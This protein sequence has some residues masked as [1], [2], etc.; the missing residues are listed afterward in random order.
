MKAKLEGMDAKANYEYNKALMQLRTHYR[1]LV[2][3]MEHYQ[4]ERRMTQKVGE[5]IIQIHNAAFND[6]KMTPLEHLKRARS[7][8]ALRCKSNS[9][10]RIGINAGWHWSSWPATRCRMTRYKPTNQSQPKS[11]D[12]GKIF[13]GK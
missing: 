2:R 12:R 10:G 4:L 8:A 3:E 11:R 7:R 5:G 9:A 6:Q 13:S 1:L